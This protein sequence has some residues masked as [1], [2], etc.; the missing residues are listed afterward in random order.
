MSG[1]GVPGA[2]MWTRLV[3]RPGVD[4]APVAVVMMFPAQMDLNR[5]LRASHGKLNA[6]QTVGTDAVSIQ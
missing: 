1:P 4:S 2:S 6:S 3:R 5:N